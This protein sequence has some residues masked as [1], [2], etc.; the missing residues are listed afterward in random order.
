MK[1]K[2]KLFWEMNWSSSEKALLLTDVLLAGILLGWL[3]SPLRSKHIFCGNRFGNAVQGTDA[4]EDEVYD[5][6]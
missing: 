3:T 6:A 1:E 2:L 5:E 4:E